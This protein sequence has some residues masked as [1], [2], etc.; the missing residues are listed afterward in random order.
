MTERTPVHY[1]VLAQKYSLAPYFGLLGELT[2]Q[3]HTVSFS[4]S[5]Y[6]WLSPKVAFKSH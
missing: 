5:R 1:K 3:L 4:D 6:C 2:T